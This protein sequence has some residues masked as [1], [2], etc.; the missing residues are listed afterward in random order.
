MDREPRAA[1]EAVVRELVA[2]RPPAEAA[3][4]L[5][6]LATRAVAELQRLARQQAEAYRGQPQWGAWAKL[7]NVARKGVLDLASCRDAAREV[8]ERQGEP[9]P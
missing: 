5:A 7:A 4:A 2:G 9:A 3:L 8:Q 6:E 1:A